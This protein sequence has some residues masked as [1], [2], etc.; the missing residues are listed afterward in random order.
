MPRVSVTDRYITL[1]HWLQRRLLAGRKLS[2]AVCDELGLWHIY[3]GGLLAHNP[4]GFYPVTGLRRIAVA[5]PE[6]ARTRIAAERELL[7]AKLE[8]IDLYYRLR[9]QAIRHEAEKRLL[10]A[11]GRR[12]RRRIR[13]DAEK[14]IG[15]FSQ[16]SHDLKTPLSMLTVPL[17]QMVIEDESIP[18]RLRLQLEKIRTAI[19]SVLRTVTHSLDAARLVTRRQ[20]PMLIPQDITVFVRQVAEVYSLVFESYGIS[21][22]LNLESAVIAEIDPIQFEKI[23]NNLL[24]NALKHNMPGGKVIITLHN[25]NRR[26]VLAI[27]DSGLGPGEDL[28][29]RRNR[30]PWAFSSH[31]YGLTIV[32][33]LVRLNRGTMQFTSRTGIGTTVVLTLP[34]APEL[35]PAAQSSRRHSFNFTM[36]EVELMA[37]ER[38]A[39]SRRRRAEDSRQI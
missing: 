10:A 27:S 38:N 6:P 26:A 35:A 28:G 9:R 12:M 36:H 4:V 7:S 3:P 39:L 29:R 33:E 24:S 5:P 25:Q 18:V 17:E 1:A 14:R 20:K 13:D 34:A 8:A 15:L 32:R 30:N 2:I 31:G 19:Y 22:Q 23:L 16:Y 21:L 11:T 37:A